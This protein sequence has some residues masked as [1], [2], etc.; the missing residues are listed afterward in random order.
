[1]TDI[2]LLKKATRFSALAHKHQRRRDSDASPYINHP[3]ELAVVLCVEAGIHDVEIL[4]AAYLR[5]TVEDTDTT[6]ND[7]VNEFG[8]TLTG[9]RASRTPSP[10]AGPS[11]ARFLKRLT[12]RSPKQ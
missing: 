7:L 12:T 8:L 2:E 9:L 5:D 4:S 1:M 6:H 10:L 11:F 3:I